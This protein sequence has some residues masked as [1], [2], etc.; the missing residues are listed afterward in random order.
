MPWLAGIDEAGYGPNLG[1]FVMSMVTVRVRKA[2]VGADLWRRLACA[3]RRAGEAADGRLVIDDSKRV[4]SPERGL[5]ELEHT[6]HCLL[7]RASKAPCTL[8][9]FWQR[10]SLTR[11]AALREEPWFR[12]DGCVPIA[13]LPDHHDSARLLMEQT[14]RHADMQFGE[15][16][17]A[18]V[19]PRQFNALVARHDSKAAVPAWALT[20]LLRRLRPSTSEALHVFVD[21]LGGRNHYQPLLQQVFPDHLVLG[22]E[23]GAGRSAY[24]ACGSSG[25][26]EIAFEPEADQRHLPVALASMLSKYIREMLMGMFNRFWQEHVPGLRPTAGYPSDARRFYDDIRAARQQLGIADELLWRGR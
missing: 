13:D 4:Y 8:R 20:E 26:L 24:R 16:C 10:H 6:L 17:F 7:P 15:F 3:V 12:T 22:R 11:F 2:D 5:K 14:C 9:Q 1:P 21:K 18:A 19:F 25:D 23:E